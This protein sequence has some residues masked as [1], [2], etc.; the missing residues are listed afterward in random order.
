MP[1]KRRWRARGCPPAWCKKR[2]RRAAAGHWRC[3]SWSVRKCL[4]AC[5]RA[6]NA[7]PSRWSRPSAPAG[8]RPNTLPRW[9]TRWPRWTTRKPTS[10]I[11]R[12]TASF[13]RTSFSCPSAALPPTRSGWAARR[14]PMKAATCSFTATPTLRAAAACSM[15]W[16]GAS[17]CASSAMPSG[18]TCAARWRAPKR[19]STCT[20]TKAR[21]WRPRA[22]TNAFRWACPWFPNARPTRPS[23]PC[24][25]TWCA[26]RPWATKRRC[27]PRCK[28]PWTSRPAKRAAPPGPGAARRQWPPHRRA[29]NSCSGA[30]CW[31]GASSAMRSLTNSPPPA[32]CRRWP[33]AWLSACPKPRRGGRLSRPRARPA[34]SCLTA[35]ATCP[36]GWGAPSATS[37]WRSAPCGRACRR[38]KSW[39]TTWC[40]RPATPNAASACKP[41]WTA[42]RGNGTCSSA[43]WRWFTPKPAYSRWSAKAAKPTSRLTA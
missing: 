18:R 23:T 29:L 17:S 26:L 43:S 27:W 4:T 41:G 6:K 40:L 24:W 2:K 39:K 5:R 9:K 32:P 22:F 7:W 13:I 28:K 38:S 12:T 14:K 1:C 11:W 8:S 25:K 34:C 35:C 36:A 42:M 19:S 21:C 33:A 37:I 16:R 31:P 3:I 10:P 30:C 20:T 15:P